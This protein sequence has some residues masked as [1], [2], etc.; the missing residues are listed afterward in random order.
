MWHIL[1]SLLVVDVGGPRSLWV[2]PREEV[3]GC[4][5]KAEQATG[6]EAVGSGENSL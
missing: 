6:S 1:F 3:L 4:V 2:I 5:R